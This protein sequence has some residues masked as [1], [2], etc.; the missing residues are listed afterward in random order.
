[1]REGD[2]AISQNERIVELTGDTLTVDDVVVAARGHARVVIAEEALRRVRLARDVVER[3]LVS[4]ETVYGLNTGL[5]SFARYRIP[6]DQLGGFSFAT[7]ADQTSSYGRPLPTDVVR[8]M[9]V[10]RANGIA[11]AGVG[12]RRELVELL[13]DALNAGVHPI[14][15]HVGSVGQGDLSEM[16]DIG[17]VLIGIGRAELDGE[18]LPGS[19][20]LARAGLEPIELAPKEAVGLISANGVTLGRGSLV[21]NDVAN[22]ADAFEIASALSLEGFAGNL[23]IIHPGAARL[24]PQIGLNAAAGRLRAVLEGSYLWEPGAA[25]NLQ[26]PLSF[27]CIPRTHGALYD[28]LAYARST[29]EAELNA[30]NDNP[31]VLVDEGTIVSVGNFD[32]VGVA[33][34]FDLVR[35]AVA[36]A[37]RVANERMQKLL[38]RHFS[39]LPSEL[40]VEEGPTNGLKPM[41]RWSAA[42]A[43][44]A[45]SLAN[46]VSL[47]YAGQVAEGVEDHASM[48]PLAVR[49]TYEVVSIAHRMIAHELVIAAQAV[50]MRGN[51]PLGR[52]TGIA[53]ATV[54]EY[55]PMLRDVADW[56]PDVEALVE[57]VA[58]G[59][60]SAQVAA[61]V[62]ERQELSE[63]EG[64]GSLSEP[65]LRALE[66]AAAEHGY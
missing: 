42:L 14:V 17:K 51:R 38:W 66:R 11:K 6:S 25:R 54:R 60:L 57:A 39:G 33:M 65:E 1:M 2:S 59:E 46:P 8:A 40:A 12:V 5:G 23:S 27:R 64:P 49:R 53:Y 28:A 34:A 36:N 4:G 30:A 10:T 52:G 32:V 21:L 62:G 20:A 48:A 58:N 19:E 45:R 47:D 50:D 41:G 37:V 22:L 9:M 61:R 56:A 16:S 18:V 31:L 55:V 43:A 35:L 7:V 26:D 44:E 63:H 13:V 24:Q 15:R 3:V 29:L